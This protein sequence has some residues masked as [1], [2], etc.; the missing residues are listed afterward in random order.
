MSALTSAAPRRF[1]VKK[2]FQDYNVKA[3]VKIYDGSAL[4]DASSTAPG[5][6]GTNVVRSY[7]SPENFIG[8]AIATVD[9]SSG[10]DGALTVTVATDGVVE[11]VVTGATAASTGALVYA[12]DGN[13]FTTTSTAN[14]AIGTIA[15]IVSGTTVLVKFQGVGYRSV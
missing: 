8:F 13:T 9:N 7:T 2:A 11:L 1:E 3:A 10:A 14:T 15:K 4:S 5:V 6:A 12:T